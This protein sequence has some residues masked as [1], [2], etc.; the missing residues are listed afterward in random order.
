MAATSREILAIGATGTPSVVSFDADIFGT[1]TLA[2]RPATGSGPGD[3]YVVQDSGLN[4]YRID[5]WDGSVWQSTAGDAADGVTESEHEVLRQLIHFID[6]GPGGGFV[7]GAF[8]E[9]LPS[10]DPFPTSY[11]WWESSGKVDKIVEL[12]LTRNANQTPATEEWQMYD[13]DGSTVLTTV[14]DTIS[15]SGVFETSRTRVIA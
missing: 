15:Y 4:I 11:I 3:M 8:M 1:G 7:S 12:T 14:T 6:D 13:E 10:A 5:I 2:E 9:T